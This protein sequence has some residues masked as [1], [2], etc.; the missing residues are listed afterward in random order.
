[1]T[2][3][4]ARP[5]PS[6]QMQAA[7]IFAYQMPSDTL[8]DREDQKPPS[9]VSVQLIRSFYSF[10]HLYPHNHQADNGLSTRRLQ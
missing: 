3:I 10:L 2:A 7:L 4:L 9:P 6:G 1:M 5:Q 8:L